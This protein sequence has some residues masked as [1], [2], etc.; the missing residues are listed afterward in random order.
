MK[1]YLFFILAILISCSPVEDPDLINVY[2]TEKGVPEITQGV[3]VK[4]SKEGGPIGVIIAINDKWND[5][6]NY[7]FEKNIGRFFSQDSLHRVAAKEAD[8]YRFELD[9]G[10][11]LLHIGSG[12]NFPHFFSLKEFTVVKGEVTILKKDFSE[13]E[14]DFSEITDYQRERGVYIPW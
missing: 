3:E 14:M 2:P 11:Y 9:E 8:F 4:V 7:D 5:L 12:K 13:Q 1:N 10:N 6:S